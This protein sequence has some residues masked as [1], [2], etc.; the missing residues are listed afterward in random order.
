MIERL[1]D[2]VWQSIIVASISIRNL[3]NTCIKIELSSEIARFQNPSEKSK[4]YEIQDYVLNGRPVYYNKDN[5]KYI[6]ATKKGFWV[7]TLR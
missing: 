4:M 7:V 1:I 2:I 3:D 5:E 6:Y